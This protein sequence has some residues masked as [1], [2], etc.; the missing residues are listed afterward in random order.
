MRSIQDKPFRSTSEFLVRFRL[1]IY[2]YVQSFNG[3]GIMSERPSKSDSSKHIDFSHPD[4]V[5][6]LLLMLA[7]KRRDHQF[8]DELLKPPDERLDLSKTIKYKTLEG[9]NFPDF[10]GIHPD[11]SLCLLQILAKRL[12]EDTR[13]L[14]DGQPMLIHPQTGIIFGFCGGTLIWFRLPADNY[15]AC[16][17]KVRFNL[18]KERRK[19]LVQA[20][21][22][23][24]SWCETADDDMVKAAYEFAG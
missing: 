3:E 12:P 4:N 22:H 1:D 15:K 14:V 8:L 18:G 20:G 13:W 24:P 17:E 23:I 5:F 10:P 21:V 9:N 7:R 11:V 16:G 19:Q 2:G 6:F